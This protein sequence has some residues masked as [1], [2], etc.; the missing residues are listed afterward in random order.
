MK[1][2]LTFTHI[3][4]GVSRSDVLNFM[5]CYENS[6]AYE[7]I[8]KEYESIKED[9]EGLL[10]PQAIFSFGTIPEN[11]T[12]NSKIPEG[13]PVV[14]SLLTVGGELSAYSTDMFQKDEYVKGMLADSMASAYLF[15]MEKEAFFLLKQ[16]CAVRHLGISRRLEVPADLPIETQMVIFRECQAENVGIRIS[17]GYMFDPVKSNGMIFE[18]SKDESLFRTQHD[19]SKCTAKKCKMRGL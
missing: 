2:I 19:C 18:L 14:Y 15:A 17:T 1:D 12:V 11:P 16:E 9:L 13:T 8:V 10:R 7:E 3:R 5:E 4:A 6:P